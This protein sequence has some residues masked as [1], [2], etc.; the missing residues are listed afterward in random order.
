MILP[1]I[2]KIF[3]YVWCATV[4]FLGRIPKGSH[5]NRQIL[6][7]LCFERSSDGHRAIPAKPLM[8]GHFS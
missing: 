3:R 7:G 2:K 1:R 5:D 4:N 6:T 8:S